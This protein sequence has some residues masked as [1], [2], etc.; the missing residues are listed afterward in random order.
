M[1]RL[2]EC[3]LRIMK[4]V[5][6]SYKATARV[7]VAAWTT[8]PI[9]TIH[10]GSGKP[11]LLKMATYLSRS[12]SSCNGSSYSTILA[13]ATGKRTSCN[14]HVGHSQNYGPFSAIDYLTTPSI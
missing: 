3:R 9:L 12:E 14:L 10:D 1:T 13:M 5:E 8:S 7:A 2:W 11:L 6:Q 4:H